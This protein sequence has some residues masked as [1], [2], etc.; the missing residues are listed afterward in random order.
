MVREPDGGDIESLYPEPLSPY[1]ESGKR[2]GE[3]LVRG[4][5]RTPYPVP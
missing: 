3:S 1:H 2:R 5:H 4:R